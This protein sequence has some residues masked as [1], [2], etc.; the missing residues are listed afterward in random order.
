MTFTGIDRALIEILGSTGSATLDASAT[1]GDN[2]FILFKNNGTGTFTLNC[3]GL[4]EI[5]GQSYKDFQQMNQHLLCVM[6]LDMLQAGYMAQ[7][8]FLPLHHLQSSD[9]WLLFI[10]IVRSFFS[11]PNLCWNINR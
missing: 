5:D 4:D 10:N 11:H 8:I 6:V 9:K 1:I 2:W 7:A 3:S